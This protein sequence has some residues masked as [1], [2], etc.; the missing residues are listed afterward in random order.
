MPTKPRSRTRWL[1][2]EEVAQLLLK[3]RGLPHLRRF[4]LVGL[5]TGT[6]SG[7]ILKLSWVPSISSGWIDLEK[8][9]LYRSGS[10]ERT[11]KKRQPPVKIPPRLLAH[12]KRWKRMDGDIRHVVHW[13]G[14]SVLRVKKAFNNA[15]DRAGL[16]RKVVPHS[17][18]H[19]AACWLMQA[20]VDIW[21]AAGFLGMTP[22]MVQDVY[23]HH[24]PAFMDKA[25]NAIGRA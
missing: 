13:N 7:A 10:A 17:L 1:T 21:E 18:R 24:H 22:Q 5:Y 20:G 4:V 3:S 8:G 16:D 23:G 6:R 25:A 19:T 14:S 11:T 2:R 15:R 9:I 12:L